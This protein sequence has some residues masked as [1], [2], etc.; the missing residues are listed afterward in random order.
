MMRTIL[1]RRTTSSIDSKEFFLGIGE[2]ESLVRWERLLEVK[3]LLLFFKMFFEFYSTVK[4]V[5]H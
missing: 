2:V 4:S 3:K 1:L 5:L